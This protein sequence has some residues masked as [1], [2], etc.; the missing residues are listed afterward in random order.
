MRCSMCRKVYLT[1]KMYLVGNPSKYWICIY[2]WK[3]WVVPSVG[4][5]KELQKLLHKVIRLRSS[6]KG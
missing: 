3:G 2:C 5:S 6:S 1:G 4:N